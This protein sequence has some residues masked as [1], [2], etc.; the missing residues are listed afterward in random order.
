MMEIL[1]GP[2]PQRMIQRSRWHTRVHC[3]FH[4]TTCENTLYLIN[5]SFPSQKAEVFPPWASRLERVLQGRALR[6]S[7]VQTIKGELSCSVSPQVTRWLPQTTRF[8]FYLCSLQKYLLS[9]GTEH[10]QF[11]HLLENMLEYEPSKRLS[12]SSALCHPFFLHHP[13]RSQV[14]RNS[15]DMSRWPWPSEDHTSV[16]ACFSFSYTSC[17]FYISIRRH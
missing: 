2:I 15:C 3:W 8:S 4:T 16:F 14:W 6:E 9:Q 5:V 17:T 7:Q 13:G 12:L 10:H 1:Q 11:F